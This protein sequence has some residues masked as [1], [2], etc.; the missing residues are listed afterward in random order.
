M[1]VSSKAALADS[2]SGLKDAGA[3]VGEF[4]D[5]LQ[6]GIK[7]GG[8]I[9]LICTLVAVVINVAG[10]KRWFTSIKQGE[11]HE[12]FNIRCKAA[13]LFPGPFFVYRPFSSR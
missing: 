6:L 9:S 11:K 1:G 2:Q 5:A 10:Y 13:A 4:R 8:V 3:G 12:G 7:I